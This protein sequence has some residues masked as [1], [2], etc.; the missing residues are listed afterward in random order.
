MC[1]ASPFCFVAIPLW[2]RASV[3]NAD[4]C[5]SWILHFDLDRGIVANCLCV[6]AEICQDRRRRNSEGVALGTGREVNNAISSDGARRN[7]A[8]R[9]DIQVRVTWPS[10]L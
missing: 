4:D 8:I 2:L 10:W 5:H 7:T 9:D 1:C 6:P 3:S